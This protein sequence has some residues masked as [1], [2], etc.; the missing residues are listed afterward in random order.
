MHNLV[1]FF[2]MDL[3]TE[4]KCVEMR[5]IKSHGT[6]LIQLVECGVSEA[7]MKPNFTNTR[8]LKRRVA[9]LRCASG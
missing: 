1:F 3:S 4:Q 7:D 8:L 6:A 2:Y 5:P 9:V